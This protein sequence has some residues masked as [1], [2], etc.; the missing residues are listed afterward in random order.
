VAYAFTNFAAWAVVIA[1]EQA[2]DKGLELDDYAGLGRRYPALALVMAVAMLSFT[3][4]PPTLGFVGKFFLFR[5]V[6]EG[7]SLASL[8][9]RAHLLSLGLLLFTGGRDYV[10]ARR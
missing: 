10:H 6:I 8:D 9:R 7:A 1:V 2:E 3:G 4:V 5:T